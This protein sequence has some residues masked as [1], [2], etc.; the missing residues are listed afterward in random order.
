MQ[1]KRRGDHPQSRRW[2]RTT[3]DSVY[4]GNGELYAIKAKAKELSAEHREQQRQQ[5]SKP[6]LAKNEGL[7][8]QHLPMV[9]PGSLLG[10]ALHYLA[11]QWPKLTRIVDNG[12]GPIDN[13]LFE[14][15]FVR[16]W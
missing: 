3:G 5:L 15:R 7:L 11:S 6:V 12:A 2:T 14:F 1:S 4:C 16:S 13:I 10:K 9:T 8:V